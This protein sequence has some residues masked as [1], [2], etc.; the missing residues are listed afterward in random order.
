[1]RKAIATSLFFGLVVACCSAAQAGGPHPIAQPYGGGFEVGE[2]SYPGER[3]R[4][5]IPIDHLVLGAEHILDQQCY[6]GGFGWPHAD[7]SATYHNIT[8]PILLGS[9]GT[10]YHTRNDS[11]LVGPVNGGAFDL[12]YRYS[13]GEA[14]FGT[15]TPIFMYSLALAAGNTTFST[16]VS[17]GLFDEL[18]A[19]TYGPD[20]F[21]TAGWIAN[22]ETGRSGAWV[23]LRSWDFSALISVARVLGQPGQ[24]ALFAQ[25]LLD[26]L[27]T[28][29]NSDPDNVYSD[30]VGLAGAVRGLAAAR[31]L[32]FPAIVAPLHPGIEGIDNLEGLAGY[33]A[34]LQN[35]DGS[36]NW[37]SNLAAPGVGDEDVQT[38]AYA[39][40]ALLEVDIMTAASYQPATEAAR[41]WLVSMQ[42]P[43]GG[44]P[45]YPGGDE[46]TEVEG[47]AVT[48]MADFDA[49]FFVDGFEA[50][51]TD[52]WT[53]VAP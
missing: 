43:D 6:N 46:N 18:A 35:P 40:L 51:T 52:L 39:L 24:D 2:W 10:F 21:D 29:D 28:L 34:S 17:T 11:F 14:R 12:T 30:I 8:G 50:G 32:S 3:E 13:N 20:D 25:G 7:C 41:D 48:A 26:G 42:L 22:I 47:E 15:F 27:N 45:E 4:A 36:W 16:H 49:V 9:L 5:A 31:L 19:G 38:T 1:M 53:A 33:L 23:N 44:F 37:H